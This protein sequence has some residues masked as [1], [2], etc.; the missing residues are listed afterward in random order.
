[1]PRITLKLPTLS[2]PASTQFAP[3]K[4]LLRPRVAIPASHWTPLTLHGL[5]F[6]LRDRFLCQPKI[7]LLLETVHLRDLHSDFIAE[8]NDPA[9]TA[10]NQLA[11][12]RI[13]DIEVILQTRKMHQP[14]HRQARH[15]HE[16]AEVAHINDQ[17][18]ITRRVRRFQLRFQKRVELD[19][20][21]VALGIGGIAF[22]V[23]DVIGGFLERMRRTVAVL[24]ESPVHNEVSIASNWRSEVRVF[25]FGQA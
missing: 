15:I 21:A 3:S 25:G 1:M 14:A 4:F 8:A 5:S 20:L 9:I 23:G 7:H 11:P 6:G 13:E 12:L 16:K 17:R 19:V 10:S 18:R 2:S 22:S 24:K